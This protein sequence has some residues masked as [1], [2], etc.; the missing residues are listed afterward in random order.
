MTHWKKYRLIS[1][2]TK[3]KDVIM[4]PSNVAGMGVF[5]LRKFKEGEVICV[6]SGKVIK[7][8]ENNNS[9]YLLKCKS[10]NNNTKR[11]D[12]IHLDSTSRQSAI[13]R[14]INDACDTY[15]KEGG[16]PKKYKTKYYT[17][18]GYKFVCRVRVHGCGYMGAL[19]T[20]YLL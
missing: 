4:A 3:S 19:H 2:R 16:V 9:Y 11:H 17:N 7:S 20:H 5:A 1:A 18:V 8:V 14:Y 15:T 6:Y 10:W 12:V 13:G